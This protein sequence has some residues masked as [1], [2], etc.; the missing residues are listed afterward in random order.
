LMDNRIRPDHIVMS[1]SG[2]Q[3]GESDVALLEP[4]GELAETLSVSS[5]GSEP[6]ELESLIGAAVMESLHHRGVRVDA[7]FHGV[8]DDH[9]DFP[10]GRKTINDIWSIMP[11]ENYV[12]TAQLTADEI[13][14]VMEET[15]TGHE[16]RALVGLNVTTEGTG[17]SR[18]VRSIAFANGRP[19]G[20]SDKYVIAFNTFDSRS[21]GHRF[22]K[23]RSLLDNAAAK[24]RLHD[25]QT[26]DALIDYF[27]RHKIVR[28]IERNPLPAAA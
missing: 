6:S 13:S 25:V 15:Y 27:R 19:L 7:A 9:T 5:R 12:V 22:M 8:F 10:A 24:C 11:Y 16:R 3:L 26:R 21:A 1:R 14:A 23:L 2:S 4:I 28:K 20:R 18:R 17:A